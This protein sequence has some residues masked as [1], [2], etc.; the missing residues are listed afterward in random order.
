MVAK[1]P[2]LFYYDIFSTHE[3]EACRSTNKYAKANHFAENYFLVGSAKADKLITT[4][5]RTKPLQRSA[6][7]RRAAVGLL[8]V[9][10]SYYF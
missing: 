4:M 5:S 10:G 7:L 1:F 8:F 9:K 2:Q 6:L 3:G